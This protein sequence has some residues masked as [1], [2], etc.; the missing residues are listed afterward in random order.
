M[1]LVPTE[2]VRR[3]V[4]HDLEQARSHVLQQFPMARLEGRNTA[5][6]RQRDPPGWPAHRRPGT[7]SHESCGG[8]SEYVDPF[9]AEG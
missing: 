7:V 3:L 5:R 4:R 9:P 1:L 2:A 6:P 8:A